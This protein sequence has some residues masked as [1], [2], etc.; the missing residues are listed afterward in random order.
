MGAGRV[1]GCGWVSFGGWGG[2]TYVF[3]RGD[4]R[5]VISED[6]FQNGSA[7]DRIEFG[8]GI[9]ASDVIVTQ[10]SD[11]ADL[12]LSIVGTTDQI[13]I[14]RG[15]S[16]AGRF[17]IEQVVFEDGTVWSLAE[18]RQRAMQ[19]SSMALP[20]LPSSASAMWWCWPR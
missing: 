20:R 19:R 6:D 16:S 10:A 4:G 1:G 18:L 14:E 3:N 2:D 15:N 13:L 9:A 12:L 17:A 5:D 8:A 11:G 7:I